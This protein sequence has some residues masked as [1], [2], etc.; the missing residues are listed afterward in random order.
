MK[1]A[2][3]SDEKLFDRRTRYP[4]V[5]KTEFKGSEAVNKREKAVC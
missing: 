1:V 2:G 5:L 3:T 4:A